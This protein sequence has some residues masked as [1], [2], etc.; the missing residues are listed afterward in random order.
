ML[1]P[2]FLFPRPILAIFHIANDFLSGFPFVFW[3]VKKQHIEVQDEKTGLE[4]NYYCC[5]VTINCELVHI[6]IA[7][8]NTVYI[9]EKL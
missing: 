6:M 7:M 8:F 3:N 4:L 2:D 9:T 1:S 5:Y